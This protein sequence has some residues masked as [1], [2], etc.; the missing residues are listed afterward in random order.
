MDDFLAVEVELTTGEKLRFGPDESAVADVPSNVSYS[1][2]IPG[3]FGSASFT[4][5]KPANLSKDDARLFASV[6]IYGPGD[7]TEY[8]GRVL[9][10][11]QV[12]ATEIRVDCEGWVAHLDD[13]ESYRFL[14][15]HGELNAW[16]G[17]SVQRRINLLGASIDPDGGQVVGDPTTGAP[18]IR[19]GLDGAWSRTKLSEMW[20]DTKGVPIGKHL[21]AWKKE[22][23]VLAADPS[24]TWRISTA[25][26]DVEGGSPVHSA[27]LLAAGPS[28]TSID[29][30]ADHTFA[31]V[32]MYYTTAGTVGGD[33]RTYGVYWIPVVV[34]RHGLTLLGSSP[35]FGLAPHEVLRYVVENGAPLLTVAHDA[36]DESSELLLH[37]AFLDPTTVRT[38]VEDIVR[39]GGMSFRI[40]DWG[41]YE[42]RGF[43]CR[44]PGSYGRTWRVSKSD[45]ATPIGSG[46]DAT[47]R[48]S[49]VFVVWRDG[50]GRQHT[51][52]APG[53]GADVES[54]LLKDSDPDNPAHAVRK[55]KVVNAGTTYEAGAL[56]YGQVRLA[57]FNAI[58]WRG[59]I[60]VIGTIRDDSGKSHP[61][62]RARGGDT[63]IVED[64]VDWP[65]LPVVQTNYDHPALRN[66]VDIGAPADRGDT[67]FA[68]MES[69]A[70]M[71]G[72]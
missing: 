12:G 20:L 11:P 50:A 54:E 42:D 49:E 14:G 44:E 17:P 26:D 37:C 41:V 57:E 9:G 29:A 70:S 28:S 62:R 2:Q 60:D 46:P 22:S 36:I 8:E 67:L 27:N 16:Q 51:I 38:V 65:E 72:A 68:R 24:W 1:T 4:L 63:I 35:N 53:S 69:A 47:R 45:V 19:T 64:E 56:F 48:C 59:S 25:Q 15:I 58:Y 55:R 10:V 5:P 18:S 13:D 40:P 39:R 33:G 7:R 71:A 52:G 6:R 31:R 21:A 61:A 23:T 32:Q 34:G 30:S 66:R 3:G 43:F